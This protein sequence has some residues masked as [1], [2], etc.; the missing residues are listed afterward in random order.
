MLACLALAQS[1]ANAQR[2]PAN[3]I[4]FDRWSRELVVESDGTFAE[5]ID[6]ALVV[7]GEAASGGVVQCALYWNASTGT[8]EILEAA[9]LKADGRRIAAPT[10]MMIE[11]AESVRS[12][13]FQDQR[14]RIVTY[15]DVDPGDHVLLKAV[16][17]RTVPYFTRHFFDDR[18]P[19]ERPAREARIVY[20]VP[21]SM[22]LHFDAIGYRRE[23]VED[24]N[25]RR[26]HVW[27]H[28]GGHPVLDE[29][30]VV[31]ATDYADRLTVSTM[32]DYRS[33]ARAY[34]ALAYDRADPT[35]AIR[36]LA[37]ELTAG[38]RSDADRAR[39]LYDWVRGNVRYGG[40][41]LGAAM[42][43][44]EHAQATLDEREGDC[45][46]QAALFEALLAS[47]GISSSAVMINASGAYLLPAVPTLGVFN[48]VLTWIPALQVFAD[49]T[50]AHV[51]FG[52]LPTA[53]S[54]KPAL[55]VK[56]GELARTPVQR[57][58]AHSTR[59]DGSID[60]DGSARFSLEDTPRGWFA[61]NRRGFFEFASRDELR[62]AS[63]GMLYLS[64][65]VGTASVR[66]RAGRSEA[67]PVVLLM[68]AEV[69]GL[70]TD[71]DPPRIRAISGV[72]VGIGQALD[73]FHPLRTHLAP[74]V[75]VSRHVDE[76]A[77]WLL[78]PDL[79]P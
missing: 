66:A 37:L 33:L 63:E 67:D 20:D 69:T 21:D 77:R 23:A 18:G 3:D 39:A 38:A 9:T 70:V 46:D 78:A 55:I 47:V 52:D 22:E 68:S 57:P 59:L 7:E 11:S 65:L 71:D 28:A 50:S 60:A 6:D 36:A 10:E 29:H 42:V 56:T 73:D 14:Y 16:H 75:C 79:M 54:D 72:G 5:T 1:L 51:L 64:R 27:H 24:A 13:V 2:A 45:K 15:V 58:L 31:A 4:W 32:R 41:H 17:R 61:A 49:T 35:P 34:T 19:P 25:G 12:G 40:T 76:Q 43:V 8:I 48:H 44:P 74:S 26:R 53:V 30:R 62:S